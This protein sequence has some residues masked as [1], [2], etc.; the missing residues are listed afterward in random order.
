MN[1]LFYWAILILALLLVPSCAK[2]ELVDVNI[3]TGKYTYVFEGRNGRDSKVSIGDETDGKWP[4]LW[5]K[6][7]VIGVFRSDGTFVGSASINEGYAGKNS[8]RFTV[9][10]NVGLSQG[11][12]IHFV[13]PYSS[14]VKFSDGSITTALASEWT[15][16]ASGSSAGIGQRS[17]A[18]ATSSYDG[19]NT[20]FT[21]SYTNASIKISLTPGEYSGYD[22]HGITLWSKGQ[23]LSGKV[24]LNLTDG[25]FE[26]SE[27][28]DYVR[29]D[30]SQPVTMET[31]KT[32]AFWLSS[33]P[34]DFTGKDLYAIVHMKG[35]D[36]TVTL[37]IRLD[38][39]GKL[40]K[41]AVTSV[42]LP[43]L[44]SSLSPKW[45]EPV[46]KRYI[47]AYGKGWAY[48]PQNTVLFTQSNVAKVIEFKA[49]GNFMKVAEPKYIQ[50]VYSSDL[51]DTRTSGTV[52]IGGSDSYSGGAHRV[53]ALT[54]NYSQTIAVKKYYSNGAKGGHL[55]ALY[56]MDKDKNIIW[57]TNLWLAIYPFVE[58]QYVNGKVLDRNIGS[59]GAMHSVNH[60][61]CNGCYFQWGRPWAFPW[62]AKITGTRT[63]PVDQTNTLEKSASNPYHFMYHTG[64]PFD[65][66]YGDGSMIDRSDDLDDLWGNPNTSSSETARSSGMKSIYDPCPEGYMVVSPALLAEVEKDIATK[67][68]KGTNINYV[69]HNDVSWSFA[70]GYLG[71]YSKSGNNNTEYEVGYW[72]N[73]NCGS[74][75]R[76]LSYRPTCE[77]P[78]MF[79][80]ERTA[81]TPI[82]CMVEVRDFPSIG[83]SGS[84]GT[85]S[86]GNGG[87]EIEDDE[88]PQIPEDFE[89]EPDDTSADPSGSFD[90]SILGNAGHPRLLCDAKGFADLKKKVSTGRLANETLYRLHSEVIYRANT[91]V[92]KD[93][94]FDPA[95]SSSSD[96]YIIVDN[97]LNCAY[98][99][100]M[101]GLPSYLSKVRNDIAK[102]CSMANWDP[103]G[104]GIGEISLTMGLAYDWLYYDL[105]LAEREAMRKSIVDKGLNPMYKN[106]QNEII[107]GNWNQVNLG[108]VAVAAL[109]VYE[110]SK[111]ASVK[112]LEKAL[113]GNYNCLNGL[114]KPD[115]NYGEGLGYWEYGGGYQA[116]FTSALKGIFGSTAGIA[117]VPGYMKSG[118]YALFMHGTMNTQFSY[119]DGGSNSDPLLLTSWWFAAQNDDPGLIFCEKRRLDKG[120]YTGTSS[121]SYR[122]LAPMVVMIRDFDMESRPV[123]PPSKEVW[124][125]QG[126]TP[127]TIVRKGWNF[128]GTD[129]Y[130]GVKGG[131]C[132]SWRTSNT[133]HAHMDA[134]SF[135][136]EAEGVRWSDDT[137][138]PTYA[139]WF[140]A[141]KEA[142]SRSGD[143]SQKGLRWDTFRVNNLGHSTIVSFTNDG[144]V[145]NKLHDNDYD[146]DGFA[147]MDAVIN[148]GGRQ[149][150]VFNMTA[151]MKGQVKSAKRTVELVNG[152][153]LVV[154]DEITALDALDCKLEWRMLTRASASAASDKVILTS[155]GK[156]RKLSVTSSSASV[157]PMYK[158]WE[159]ARPGTD[160][161]KTPEEIGWKSMSWDEPLE[162]RVIA[163][164]SATVPKGQT[165]KFVTTLKK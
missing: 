16:N 35:S 46:E 83:G 27:S 104:L 94:T 93:K 75:A 141:M 108:G 159:A 138:R 106:T 118:E 57:G 6:G 151:P 8:A 119:S 3:P 137:M 78:L 68:V 127:V 142:G 53:V 101:T 77:I 63:S 56:V 90:Y 2:E 82:R 4:V 152:T 24:S 20:R 160:Y 144:S 132:N 15:Q 76:M 129:V 31:G 11:E 110:K 99:Y 37:P 58:T 12:T 23:K 55:S 32:Y 59:D 102:V 81:A 25:A 131:L 1:R 112:L 150:A 136:F 115:G 140:A 73:S 87:G 51:L 85:G 10:S 79:D 54:S 67:A 154:T 42:T 145:K 19:E 52:Y 103:S 43:S 109:A 95:L 111:E 124:S 14:D 50:V 65:W 123:N 158:T 41:Q 156:V 92:S 146:V 80:R 84:S 122:L 163:G 114:Y 165:V 148:S 60:W 70:G 88:K 162:G 86:G 48:G 153:D 28:N 139:P 13:Y 7:D 38:S 97:I 117:E 21:L 44:S 149:G 96:S 130:L 33:L 147:T 135:V 30:F 29:T 143:T 89:E 128:D 26:V 22:L 69:L 113:K 100:K 62:T 39:A 5:E 164:W 72:S 40:P 91:I 116:C 64:E 98:A 36:Q 134:G 161:W 107:I 71:N 34:A 105:T 66:Y 18:H 45:Y 120:N 47:A 157:S 125:G 9:S 155:D 126:E 61:T 74:R 17:L 49:R 133:S 121:T